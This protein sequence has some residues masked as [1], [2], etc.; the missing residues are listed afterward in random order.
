MDVKIEKK[1]EKFWHV[2][3][4]WLK[5]NLKEKY[6]VWAYIVVCLVFVLFLWLISCSAAKMSVETAI[7]GSTNYRGHDYIVFRVQDHDGTFSVVHDPDCSC[8]FVD[9][10]DL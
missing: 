6:P 3:F 2:A 1:E 8:H 4:T 5:S 9:V 7:V 10:I